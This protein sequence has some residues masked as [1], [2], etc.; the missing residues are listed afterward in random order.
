[1]YIPRHFEITDSDEIFAFVE[2]NAFGQL[3]SHVEGRFFC[4]H[5][6]FLVTQDRSALICHLAK[7]NPQH[8][9]LDGQEVLITLQGAHDYISP[10][11]YAGPGV[12]TWNY[13]AVHIYGQCQVFHDSAKLKEVI[14]TLAKKYEAAFASP[15]QPQYG[16]AMLTAIVG[17]EITITDVQCKYKL[18]QNRPAQDRVQVVEKLKFLGS[19]R[20]AEAMER[21]AP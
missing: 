20:L 21:H 16:A 15:W 3:I 17:V 19:T 7:Q 8:L 2:A 12:P 1:M 5:L 9:E 13:Q 18:S 10:S 4:S 6:P 11:W 14:E